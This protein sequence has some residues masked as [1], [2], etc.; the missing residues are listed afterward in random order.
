VRALVQNELRQRVRARRWWI[1]LGLWT[2]LQ[3]LIMIPVRAAGQNSQNFLYGSDSDIPL[4]PLMFGTLALLVLGLS[5]LVIPS[6]TATAINGERDRGTL[7]VLQTTL[8]TPVQIAAAKFLSAWI[9]ATVFIVAT[10]PI[11]LWCY[12]EGGVS[13]W[14][15]AAVYLVLFV[16]TGVLLAV[17]L[18]ASALFRKPALS[19]V[20]AYLAVGAL[21]IGTLIA[22]GLAQA[23]APRTGPYGTQETGARWVLLAPNPFVVLADAA[24]RSERYLDDPLAAI[25]EGIRYLREPEPVFIDAPRGEPNGNLFQ[26]RDEP[27]PVWPTGLTVDLALAGLALALTVQRLQVP[28][29]RLAPGHRVA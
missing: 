14:R 22:F 23:T 27:S 7:A 8:Y 5:C 2:L 18:A 13:F 25:Q 21:T 1:L 19:A 26:E 29:R 11:A 16:I 24:P 12:I 17:A 10:L 20:I 9:S 6:L 28:V 15:A 3:F 4:G